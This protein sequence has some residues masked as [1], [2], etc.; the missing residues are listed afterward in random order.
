MLGQGMG[1]RSR[2]D[3]CIWGYHE[4]TDLEGGGGRSRDNVAEEAKSES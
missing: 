3:Y 2:A 4:S 1:V